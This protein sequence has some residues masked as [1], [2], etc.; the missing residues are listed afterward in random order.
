MSMSSKTTVGDSANPCEQV[1]A[2]KRPPLPA[3]GKPPVASVEQKPGVFRVSAADV[4]KPAL[5]R[6]QTFEELGIQ[7][8]F[9]KAVEEELTKDEKMLWLGR[10]SLNP[11]VY[12]PRTNLV[13]IGVIALALA[14]AFLAFPIF[15]KGAPIAFAIIFSIVL[16]L[17]GILFILSPKFFN[18][19][20]FYHACYVV[21]NRRVILFERGLL[22]V[23]PLSPNL[24]G[25]RCKGY[26][27]HEIMALERRNNPQAPGAGDLIFTYI[28]VVGKGAASFPGTEG[29]LTSTNTPQ[30]I[31][32]GFFYLD[33]VA[34]VEQLIRTTLLENLVK[35]LDA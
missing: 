9:R 27:P 15:V 8:E 22:G 18:P 3:C 2:G 26:Y 24:I 19:A 12:P 6:L 35:I 29:T 13:I 34:G 20:N 17:I 25:T 14:V 10:P 32:R 11:A 30:R 21:T 1:I 33:D 4:I 7:N 5:P 16:G 23:D 28:M 31:P